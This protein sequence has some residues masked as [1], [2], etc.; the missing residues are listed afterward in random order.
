LNEFIGFLQ[1]LFEKWGQV[2]VRRMFGGQGG[3]AS[4]ALAGHDVSQKRAR[5]ADLS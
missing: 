1:E 4:S 5:L 2:T 3:Q